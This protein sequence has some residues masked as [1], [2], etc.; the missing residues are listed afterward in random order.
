MKK[1]NLKSLKLNKKAVSNFKQ[2]VFG[3]EYPATTKDE[4]KS[5]G[6]TCY[7]LS[8]FFTQCFLQCW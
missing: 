1:K 2:E 8:Q 5:C 3:G 7:D 4:A 6:G